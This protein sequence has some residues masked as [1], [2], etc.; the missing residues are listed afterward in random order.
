M[1]APDDGSR[2]SASSDSTGLLYP[3]LS[4]D[5]QQL[6]VTRRSRTTPTSGCV[7]SFAA[8]GLPS[9]QTRP[10]TT[11]RCGRQTA[12]TSCSPRP[13]A[14]KQA[15]NLY[16]TRAG[17][18][19]SQDLLLET[20]NFKVPQDWSK[21]GFLL[22]FEIGDKHGRDLWAYDPPRRHRRW[23]T[24]RFEGESCAVLPRWEMGGALDGTNPASSR[25]SHR[26]SR[27]RNA[28]GPSRRAGAAIHDGGRTARSLLH[29]TGREAECRER[30]DI[31][32]DFPER[33]TGCAVPASRC[34]RSV[35][36]VQTSVRR[37]EGWSLLV[38]QLVDESATP[39]TLV[40]NWQPPD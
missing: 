22:Y 13:A 31:G 21:D 10:S 12:H 20:P 14:A 32:R 2:S 7:I 17:G 36:L 18:V 35:E 4:P 19:A 28:D 6:A 23:P 16:T 30:D 39:I 26:H 9:R 34:R 15:G 38:N 40:L 29:R 3:E 8:A 37:R 1:T 11:R 27:M 5:D 24:R 25:W 33:R